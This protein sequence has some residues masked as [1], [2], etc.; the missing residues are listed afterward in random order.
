MGGRGPGRW[1]GA[2]RQ[3]PSGRPTAP[4][5]NGRPG[6]L[7]GAGCHRACLALHQTRPDPA[8]QFQLAKEDYRGR[9]TGEVPKLED[10]LFG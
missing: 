2:L 3:R 1:T 9:V 5:G 10:L 6:A 4:W 7:A 8:P